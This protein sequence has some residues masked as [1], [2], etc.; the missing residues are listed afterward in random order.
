M[1]S[2]PAKWWLITAGGEAGLGFQVVGT[3]PGGFQHRQLG[4][5]VALRWST[6]RQ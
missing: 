3:L 1:G 2:T 6:G 5:V 4:Y